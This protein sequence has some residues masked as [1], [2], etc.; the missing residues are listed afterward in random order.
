MKNK[1]E[2]DAYF[3]GAKWVMSIIRDKNIL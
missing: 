1:E 3:R 2:I